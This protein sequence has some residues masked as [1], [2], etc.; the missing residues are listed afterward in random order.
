MFDNILIKTF[1][2]K[3]NLDT[4]TNKN[5]ASIEIKANTILTI[6]KIHKN[7]GMQVYINKAC[8]HKNETNKS[9]ACI[10]L[11]RNKIL[12][13]RSY[14]ITGNLQNRCLFDSDASDD[15]FVKLDASTTRAPSPP[16]SWR[17]TTHLYQLSLACPLVPKSFWVL[18]G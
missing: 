8:Y 17:R 18:W 3:K 11:A 12:K 10:A 7:K 6:V 4:W 2:T 13:W 14:Q 5:M 9:H 15:L 16:K 1:I